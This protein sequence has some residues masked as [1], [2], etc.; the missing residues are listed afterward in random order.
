MLK[1]LIKFINTVGIEYFS[2]SDFDD[3]KIANEKNKLGLVLDHDELQFKENTRSEAAELITQ[4]GNLDEILNKN[5]LPSDAKRLPNYRSYII[6][7]DFM[8]VGFVF[9]NDIPNYDVQAN[10]KLKV[11]IDQCKEIQF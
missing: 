2:E 6:W 7:R 3:L 8:K 11:I 1:S 9:L 4:M 5:P 10:N